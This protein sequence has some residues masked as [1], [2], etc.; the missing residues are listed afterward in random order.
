MR[1]DEELYTQKLR[2][3]S[4]TFFFDLKQNDGGKFLK[5]TERSGGRRNSIYVPAAGL[6]EF[7]VTVD[8][9]VEKLDELE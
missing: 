6:G 5:I 7:K 3:E 9:M 2:V 4:K 8:N 1:K